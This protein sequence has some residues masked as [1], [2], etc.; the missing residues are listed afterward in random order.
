M[1]PNSSVT[2]DI[3]VFAAQGSNHLS[4]Q[5]TV[6]KLIE[7]LGDDRELF[8]L[9]LTRCRDALYVELESLATDEKSILGREFYDAFQDPKTLLL[10][11]QSFHS[12]PVVETLAL[13][14]RQILE[15][16]IFASYHNGNHIVAETTGICTGVL[17]AIIAASFTTY[18]SEQYIQSVTETFR[19]AFWVAMRTSIFCRQA[20]GDSW[21][22][23][24]WCLSTFGL[25]I[26]DVEEKLVEYRNLNESVCIAFST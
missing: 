17:P 3:L 26:E 10:P 12:H 1:N 16:M 25:P 13:F 8:H 23:M 19:L 18:N 9:I 14:T 4:D 24:P 22:E 2:R 11:P 15:L 21:R 7:F 5:P 20:A 6:D